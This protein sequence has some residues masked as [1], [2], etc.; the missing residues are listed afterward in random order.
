ML[1]CQNNHCYKIVST[2]NPGFENQEPK[3]SKTRGLKIE[4]EIE[5]VIGRN[6]G[7]FSKYLETNFCAFILVF[8]TGAVQISAEIGFKI[9]YFKSNGN[10]NVYLYRYMDRF[11]T[12]RHVQQFWTSVGCKNDKKGLKGLRSALQEVEILEKKVESL[13]YGILTFKHTFTV[14]LNRFWL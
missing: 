5:I 10:N 14:K 8:N 4:K 12:S 6:W 1:L 7:W 3:G 11:W 9:H 13:R 2:S